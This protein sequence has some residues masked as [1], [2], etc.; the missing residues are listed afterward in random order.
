VHYP[1]ALPALQAYRY[2][3]HQP[4]DF[5]VATRCAAEVLSLPM[6]P[7]MEEAQVRHVVE[8]LAQVAR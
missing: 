7:E 1:I 4:D 2:L 6:F 3:E 8:S 5:P